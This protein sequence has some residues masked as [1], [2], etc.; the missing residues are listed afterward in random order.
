MLED[1]G[2]K[3]YRINGMPDHIHM[4]IDLNPAV[5]LAALVR[6]VKAKSSQWMRKSGLF[7]AFEGW[8]DG[9]FA[10]SKS[11]SDKDMVIAYIRGQEAHHAAA[12]TENEVEY[13]FR[14]SGFTL[15]D[16]DLI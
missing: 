13:L 15:H 16:G 5:A 12:A 1:S 7:P 11:L 3:L 6:D 10:E 9:Y 14:N 8:G 2:C 4:L